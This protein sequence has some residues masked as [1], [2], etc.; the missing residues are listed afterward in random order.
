MW[1][2]EK[3]C[4]AAKFII[5]ATPRGYYLTMTMSQGRSSSVLITEHGGMGNNRFL[6]PRNK[7]SFKLDYLQKEASGLHTEEK[8]ESLKTRRESCHSA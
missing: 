3:L 7:T 8:D 2:E 6:G 4:I 5:H 1:N